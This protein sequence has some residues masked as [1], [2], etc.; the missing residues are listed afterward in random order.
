MKA[1]AFPGGWSIFGIFFSNVQK[2]LWVRE[3]DH[4]GKSGCA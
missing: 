2:A 4:N 1:V 3:D